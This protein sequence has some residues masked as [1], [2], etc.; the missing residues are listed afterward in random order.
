VSDATFDID[1]NDIAALRARHKH[2]RQSAAGGGGVGSAVAQRRIAERKATTPR[3][4]D[5]DGRKLKNTGRTAQL[6]V[7][8]RPDV[9]E[10]ALALAAARGSTMVGLIEDLIE[11]AASS[12]GD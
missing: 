10:L 6:N 12:I 11:A 4:A 2:Q 7:T 3:I 1:E 8:I 5:N 9:K